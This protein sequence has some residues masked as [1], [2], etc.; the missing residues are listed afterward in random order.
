MSFPHSTELLFD[1]LKKALSDYGLDPS[2]LVGQ[3]N[4][5]A[6]NISGSKSRLAVKVMQSLS[7]S[8]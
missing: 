6:A 4:D 3:C 2:K 1:L 5:G 8:A 7:K